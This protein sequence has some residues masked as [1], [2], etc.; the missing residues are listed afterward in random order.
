M[1]I[2]FAENFVN[3][4]K[5][6]SFAMLLFITLWPKVLKKAET[7]DY[8]PVK[9]KDMTNVRRQIEVSQKTRHELVKLFNTTAMS[10]WRALSFKNDS[11][12]SKK[13][14]K[15]ALE[16]DGVIMV[17]QPAIETIHDADNF[18]RQ[19]FPNDVMIEANKNNGH[20]DLLKCGEIVKSWDNVFLS[21]LTRIQQDAIA[22][23]GV[24]VR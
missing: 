13:I 16:I 22:L 18:M 17:L 4:N 11:E 20:V 10:V 1:R 2:I 9:V 24:Y 23:C 3:C 19:Y 5:M 14:R 15:A 21:D 7:K 8:K 6:R 12:T